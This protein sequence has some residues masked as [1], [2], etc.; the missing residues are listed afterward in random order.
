MLC[1]LEGSI[2]TECY[3]W[4]AY[5]LLG[6]YIYSAYIKHLRVFLQEL[7]LIRTEN[8]YTTTYT[9]VYVLWPKMKSSDL[10]GVVQLLAH[11]NFKNF[12]CD[13]SVSSYRSSAKE[14]VYAKHFIILC[15]RK[16]LFLISIRIWRSLWNHPSGEFSGWLNSRNL[17][18]AQWIGSTRL[19]EANEQGAEKNL[20]MGLRVPLCATPRA[21]QIPLAEYVRYLSCRENGSVGTTL[22]SLV[23]DHPEC[24]W[25]RIKFITASH[26]LNLMT[27]W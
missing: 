25:K 6:R 19:A 16:F 24:A 21:P 3:S 22:S 15:N 13:I 11:L 14:N 18:W 5:Y 1:F 8:I 27:G 12:Q 10:P 23:F 20:E 4:D 2:I 17:P 26:S 7:T 9:E